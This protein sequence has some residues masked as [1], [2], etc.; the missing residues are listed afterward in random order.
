M[1]GGT[2]DDTYVVDNVGDQ[3]VETGAAGTDLVQSSIS[4]TLGAN[5]EKLTLTGSASIS[6][7]GNGLANTII[8]NSAA[9]IIKGGAGNDTLSGEAGNDRINGGAGDDTINGGL[10]ADT[11]VGGDGGDNFL[12]NSALSKLSLTSIDEINDFSVLDD[13]I[14]LE[15]AVFTELGPFATLSAGAFFIGAA[16]HDRDD[17]IIYDSTTGALMYDADGSYS[18]QAKTFAV[19][20]AGLA[21]THDDFVIV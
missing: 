16:A 6:G 15:N 3:V 12:F 21:L 1:V 13:T 5:V 11:L 14:Q 8:G 4:Y 10:G 7:T 18:G 17:R 9:N 20:D 2:G 19:L